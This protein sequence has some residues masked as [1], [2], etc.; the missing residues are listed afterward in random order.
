MNN[1]GSKEQDRVAT[2]RAP[3]QRRVRRRFSVHGRA[4]SADWRVRDQHSIETVRAPPGKRRR[5]SVALH[6]HSSGPKT[7]SYRDRQ[8]RIEH[9][10]L[11]FEDVERID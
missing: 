6:F 10:R 3:V 11:H 2:I 5:E 9:V 7:R 1:L 8:P 4:E